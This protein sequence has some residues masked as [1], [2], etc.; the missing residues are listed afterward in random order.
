MNNTLL[1]ILI[2]STLLYGC[3]EANTSKNSQYVTLRYDP[4]QCR[5]TPWS[6]WA[7]NGN[8]T[9]TKPPSP[10]ELMMTYYNDNYNVKIYSYKEIKRNEAT[11]QACDI[12]PKNYYIIVNVSDTDMQKMIG[13]GWKE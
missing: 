6:A 10:S 12:C 4:M 13:M 11:C 8:V 7:T 9:F 2:L 1:L 5:N 3:A